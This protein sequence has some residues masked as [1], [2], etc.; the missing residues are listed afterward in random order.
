[1]DSLGR[2][3]LF[4]HFF[5]L[6]L[7]NF[8]GGLVNCFDIQIARVRTESYEKK[9]WCGE[10][11]NSKKWRLRKSKLMKFQFYHSFLDD[12]SSLSLSIPFNMFFHFSQLTIHCCAWAWSRKVLSV[13]SPSPLSAKNN[14]KAHAEFQLMKMNW[15]NSVVWWRILIFL[16][17][18]SL[19]F[20]S[21]KSKK[22]VFSLHVRVM[23]KNIDNWSV[24]WR[25]LKSTKLAG[26]SRWNSPLSLNWKATDSHFK[27]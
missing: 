27:R 13:R 20:F 3:P 19:F 5:S 7:M 14:K 10:N 4:F 23:Q 17:H 8:T 25:A 11:K 21:Q 22:S 24:V 15:R 9:S 12:S 18:F 6:A 26:M 2:S 16:F 1:M